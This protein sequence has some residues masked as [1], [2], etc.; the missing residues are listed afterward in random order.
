MKKHSSSLI[1]V[2]LLVFSISV[3]STT[4]FLLPVIGVPILFRFYQSIM[5]KNVK[6]SFYYFVKGIL[7]LI[8]VLSIFILYLFWAYQR[9]C[10]SQSPIKDCFNKSFINIYSYVQD[11][12]WNV[13][14]LTYF[15]LSNIVFILIGLP[16]IILSIICLRKPRQLK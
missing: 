1:S 10:T 7:V 6:D 9:V 5:A 4:L 3:R 15:K 16:S 8:S 2:L 12:Y 13:G 14:F 11:N